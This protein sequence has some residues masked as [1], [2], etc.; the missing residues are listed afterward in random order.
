MAVVPRCAVLS[1]PESI[2]EFVS[3]GNGALADGIDTIVFEGVEHS[4][5]VP[6][7]SCAVV[8]EVVLN[9]DFDPIA[10]AGFQPGSRVLFVEDF[11]SIRSVHTIAVDVF[12][13]HIKVILYQSSSV[14][15]ARAYSTFEH[16][17]TYRT[18]GANGCILVVVGEDVVDATSGVC[19]HDG[20]LE[21]LVPCTIAST[22][23]PASH[24]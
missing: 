1:D 15:G 2:G 8:F 4:D 18:S 9:G 11:A 17:K 12:V 7:D 5:T 14:F 19:I 13:R 20:F 23:S 24:G 6:V 22:V 10:P 21:P 3:R 16:R